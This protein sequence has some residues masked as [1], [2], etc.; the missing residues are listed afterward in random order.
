MSQVRASKRR[1]RAELEQAIAELNTK[2]RGPGQRRAC[3]AGGAG[4]RIR[5]EVRSSRPTR[6]G[7]SSGPW[8]SSGLRTSCCPVGSRR[9]SAPD[10]GA[11]REIDLLTE[12]VRAFPRTRPSVSGAG[13]TSWSVSVTGAQRTRGRRYGPHRVKD[14]GRWANA[15]LDQ[16]TRDGRTHRTPYL[17]LVSHS[18]P[19]SQKNEVGVIDGVVLARPAVAV[20]VLGILRRMVIE[21]HRLGPDHGRPRGQA[22][23]PLRV[24][25]EPPVLPGDQR[26]HEDFDG[27][28]KELR[29]SARPTSAPG[30]GGS[31]PT[32]R[33]PA[34]RPRSM[35][36]FA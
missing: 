2:T 29:R 28:V 34:T 20:Q 10:R 18:F 16:I 12:V 8:R 21:V 15:Y 24:P 14:T 11:G 25:G 9:C 17:L 26:D 3:G 23:R 6:P 35:S 36:R 27:P 31:A 5:A 19:A 30:P 1:K 7:A 4:A 22:R 32:T 33:W 13:A